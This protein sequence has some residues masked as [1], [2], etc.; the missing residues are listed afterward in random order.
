MVKHIDQLRRDW[1]GA[2]SVPECDEERR[3]DAFTLANPGRT[4]RIAD[5]RG[6][7]WEWTTPMGHHRIANSRSPYSEAA[8]CPPQG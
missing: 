3:E 4:L 8:A 1:R 2:P 6:A 5:P 7:D